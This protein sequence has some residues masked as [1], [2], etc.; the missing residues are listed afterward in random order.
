MDGSFSRTESAGG[1]KLLIIKILFA[2][3]KINFS[4]SGRESGELVFMRRPFSVKG[5]KWLKVQA[6][7]W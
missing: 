7:T 2:M 1:I 5:T 3:A 6:S 4:E